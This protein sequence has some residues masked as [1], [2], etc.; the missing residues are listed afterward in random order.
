MNKL[1]ELYKKKKKKDK[2]LDEYIETHR[3]HLSDEAEAIRKDIYRITDKINLLEKGREES[4]GYEDFKNRLLQRPITF[5]T[6]ENLDKL[7]HHCKKAIHYEREVEHKVVLEL[8]ERY[9]ELLTKREEDKKKIAEL[10]AKLEFYQW[11]DLDNLKFEE[12]MKEFIPKQKVKDN[13]NKLNTRIK[14]FKNPE[15]KKYFSIEQIIYLLEQFE[16]KLLEDK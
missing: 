1:E 7:E 12:Y 13:F 5:L 14:E 3:N 4:K 9:K 11:G 10:E 15:R 6:E 8:L 16:N 2:E